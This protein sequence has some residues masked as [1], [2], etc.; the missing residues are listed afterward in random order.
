MIQALFSMRL[1]YA[2]VFTMCLHIHICNS[3]STISS[4]N[5]ISD[6]KNETLLSSNG[7]FKLGF[8]SPKNSPYRYVGIWFNNASEQN[9]VWVANRNNPIRRQIGVFKI[10]LNGNIAVMN[11]ETDNDIIW[12]SNITDAASVN[13]TAELLSTG[14]LVLRASDRSGQSNIVLWQSFDYPTDTFQVGMKVGLDR[15]T[16]MKRVLSSW[17]SENDP[18]I[19]EYSAAMEVYGLPQLFVY[20]NSDPVWRGGPWNGKTLSGVLDVA[21]N[22]K[23]YRMDYA[24]ESS[25]FSYVNS[26]D[27]VLSELDSSHH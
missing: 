8:F 10:M 25:L 12:S 14:N 13:A 23:A 3:L 26:T 24:N 6:A 4:T 27:E 7:N 20:K 5:F 22:L 21:F 15:R 2:A 9:L 17:K 18:S 19:G 1:S 11:G 16:N